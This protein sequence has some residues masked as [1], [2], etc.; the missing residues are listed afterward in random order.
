[1]Q[2]TAIRLGP[3]QTEILVTN[4]GVWT[5]RLVVQMLVVILSV[6]DDGTHRGERS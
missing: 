5:L 2:D 6:T 3:H 4:L 1:M